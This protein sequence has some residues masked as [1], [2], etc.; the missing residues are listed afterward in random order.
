MS[1]R[2]AI[3]DLVRNVFVVIVMLAVGLLVG[4]RPSGSPLRWL[5]GIGLLLLLSFAFSW[6]GAAI[7]LLVRHRA[8]TFT[9]E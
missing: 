3:A 7:G 4:F 2:P 6:I 9:L 8:L 5:G 1:S